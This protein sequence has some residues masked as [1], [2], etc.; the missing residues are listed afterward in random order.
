MNDQE[1]GKQQRH[2]HK[3]HLGDMV[4]RATRDDMEKAARRALSPAAIE[5]ALREEVE[6]RRLGNFCAHH[7]KRLGLPQ[8]AMARTIQLSVDHTQKRVKKSCK[9]GNPVPIYQVASQVVGREAGVYFSL[10]G[11]NNGPTVEETMT[12]SLEK[13]VGV[14]TTDSAG[15]SQPETGGEGS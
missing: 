5:K 4:N 6:S 12:A 2:S 11:F 15:E 10:F 7:L 9:T 3:L 14:E 1:K 13:Q 8:Q